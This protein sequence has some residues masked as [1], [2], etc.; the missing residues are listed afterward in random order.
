[1]F[2]ALSAVLAR[3]GRMRVT[4]IYAAALA[5]VAVVVARL[6]P[7][8]QQELLRHVSTNLRNLGEGR[9]GTLVSSAFVTESNRLHLWLPGLVA[10][11]AL[12]ELLW[13]SRRLVVAFVVG[14]VGATLLVAGGISVAL[15]V[16]WVSS[17]IVDV[18][19]VG[20]SYGAV[21]VMGS[22]T[23]AIPRRW[24]AGWAGS[25]LA[26][27]FGS[28]ALGGGDFTNVGH[29]VALVLGMAVGARFGAP[30][31]WTVPRYGLLVVAVGFS[32]LLMAYG[33]LTI[34][35]AAGLA[36]LGAVAAQTLWLIARPHGSLRVQTNSAGEASIQSDSQL[37]GGHSSS[38]PGISHS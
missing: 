30:Q 24:R 27:A 3:L 20:M 16:G 28:A 11:L 34:T 6:A 12:G 19:D 14:H 7:E 29:A 8:V 31:Q 4:L 17:S 13:E 25:W 18:T 23:A 35:A 36:I 21:A 10:V 1:V 5:A 33:I 15:A 37:S 32:Y 38:S 22:F 26:V 9:I 2:A